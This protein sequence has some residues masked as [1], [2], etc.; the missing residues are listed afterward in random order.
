MRGAPALVEGMAAYTVS[1]V[2]E[3]SLD[4]LMEQIASEC[5]L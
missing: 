4:D 3:E 1:I 5:G 2:Y